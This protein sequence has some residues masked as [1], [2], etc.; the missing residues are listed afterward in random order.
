MS[1]PSSPT[2]LGNRM[3]LAMGTFASVRVSAHSESATERALSAA[4]KAIDGLENSLHP[5]RVGSDI[6][7]INIAV[8]GSVI[9][10]GNETLRVLKIAAEIYS[11]S[12]GRFDPCLPTCDGRFSSLELAATAVIIHERVHLDLG[13]IAKGFAVDEALALLG[14][15]EC[16]SGSVNI[17]GEVAAFGAPEMISL[18]RADGSLSTF[19]LDNEA[20]AITDVN[21][22]ARP[23]EHQGYYQREANRIRVRNYAAIAAPSAAIADALTK[24][25]LYCSDKEL[26]PILDRFHA[27]LV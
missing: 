5:G 3:R 2:F 25:A 10:V 11:A 4:F 7:A 15:H 21:S 18:C 16:L 14:E 26:Q 22:T 24:C 27:R 23:T 17:G 12:E 9:T 8:S 20:V 13:G 1:Q 6:A 19:E